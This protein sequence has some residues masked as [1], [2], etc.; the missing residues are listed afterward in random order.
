MLIFIY[1]YIYHC[2]P[3]PSPTH[4][5]NGI[6]RFLHQHIAETFFFQLFWVKLNIGLFI[7][8]VSVAKSFES[9]E[10][11]VCESSLY[12]FRREKLSSR[13]PLERKNF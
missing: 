10:V 3:P 2:T 1:I 7:Y 4:I 5:E 11:L 9:K 6:K 8:E 13:N 12:I